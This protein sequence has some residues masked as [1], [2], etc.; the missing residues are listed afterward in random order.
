MRLTVVSP[1]RPHPPPMQVQSLSKVPCIP[2]IE[3]SMTLLVLQRCIR[4][5]SSKE[6][7]SVAKESL[8]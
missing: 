1:R 8:P 5:E 4:E 6:E 7:F 2:V 3:R